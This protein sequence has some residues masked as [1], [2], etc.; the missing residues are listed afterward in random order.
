M[1][2]STKEK[3]VF[4]KSV[5]KKICWKRTEFTWDDPAVLSK[6]DCLKNFQAKSSFET[7]PKG[8]AC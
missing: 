5:G 4:P 6:D 8:A 1:G 2:D 7:V 3:A